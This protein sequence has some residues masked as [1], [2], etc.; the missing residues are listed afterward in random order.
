MKSPRPGLQDECHAGSRVAANGNVLAHFEMALSIRE[1]IKRT[2][3]AVIKD[4]AQGLA[5]QLA[6][7]FVLALFP[8]LLFLLAVASFFPLQNLTDDVVGLLAPFAPR[9]ILDIITQELTRIGNGNHGG[10]LTVGL[11]GALWSSSSAMVAVIGAMNK[12][13]DIDERRPWWRVRL[14][15]IAITIALSVLIVIA[16]TLVVAGPEL[17]DALA[18]LFAFGDVFTWTWRILQWPFVFVMVAVGMGVIYFFAPHARQLWVWITPGSLVATVLWM[19]GSLGFR[20]YVVEF[21]NYEATYGALGGVILLLLWFW[22]SGLVIVIGAEIN[23]ELEH[24]SAWGK[25]PGEKMPRGEKKRIGAAAARD[26][27]KQHPNEPTALPP[28]PPDQA[29][30]ADT[31]VGRRLT[32][33]ASMA[34]L[35]AHWWNR[36][37]P[38]HDR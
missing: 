27:R 26:W 34:M 14:T 37:R 1:L 20:L 11:V 6:Y 19:L 30:L 22:L 28:P 29:S 3:R 9:E 23:A 17:A 4:D 33:A 2:F 8:T 12:A 16:F 13:Y 38:P 18:R 25:A 24:A 32:W 15:A 35:L 31:H 21:G 5:S 36:R 7:Y 10:L